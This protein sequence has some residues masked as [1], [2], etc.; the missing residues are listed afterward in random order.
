MDAPSPHS[1]IPAA[2]SANS[3][4]ETSR[5]AHAGRTCIACDGEMGQLIRSLDWSRTP[6]GSDESWSP[7][8]RMVVQLMLANRFPTILWWGPQFIQFYNDPYRPIPGSKHP[9]SLCQ[10]ASECW[11]EIWHVIGPLIE[12]PFHG[13]PPTW[14]D[15]IFLE[16]NRHGFVEECH[17]TP[18]TESRVLVP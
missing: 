7:A 5:T 13:G 2:A 18:V 16:I 14:D 8:L 12:T 9:R 4:S 10:R 17:S 15:D 1:G 3:L 11:S 6:I